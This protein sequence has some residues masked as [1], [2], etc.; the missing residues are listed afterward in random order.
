MAQFTAEEAKARNI[1]KM[2]HALG[3]QYSALWQEVAWLHAKWREYVELFGTG[4]SR[5]D[6]LNQAAPTFFRLIQDS[7]WEDILLHIARLTDPPRSIGKCNLTICNLIALA[8]HPRAQ[9]T[10]PA[11]I[12]G[13]VDK[14]HFS[15]DWRNRRIAHRDLNLSLDASAS[16]LAP[17]SRLHVQDALSAIT[18]VLNEIDAV[19][20]DSQT[21]FE[22]IPGHPGGAL[23]LLY[24]LDDG[25]RVEAER[26]ER[27]KQGKWRE[28]DFSR[29][30]L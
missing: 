16:P 27:L 22:G 8:T 6:L 28:G 20:M 4:S 3:E 25:V 2:G 11:L 12:E 23:S 1:E 17:A 13:T 9:A 24:V 14:A 15:R 5:V 29:R 18:A 26:Q 30:Q 7:L 10:L 21:F 19:Y